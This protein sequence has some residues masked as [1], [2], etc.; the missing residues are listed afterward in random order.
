MSIQRFRVLLTILFLVLSLA[1]ALGSTVRPAGAVDHHEAPLLT[2]NAMLDATDFY[3]FV[4]PDGVVAGPTPLAGIPFDIVAYN[5]ADANIQFDEDIIPGFGSS[6]IPFQLLDANFRS[7][8]PL[9]VV[10]PDGSTAL[11]ELGVVPSPTT[12]STGE[13]QLLEISPDGGSFV[14]TLDIYFLVTFTN[15]ADGAV[16]VV[17][18][19]AE[20]VVIRV[21]AS[22][23]Y[24]YACPDDFLSVFGVTAD[25]CPG[26]QPG[27]TTVF[28]TTFVDINNPNNPAILWQTRPATAPSNRPPVLDPIAD[29]SVN[30]GESLTVPVRAT[31][32]DGHG[33]QLDVEGLPA[34]ASFIDN[35]DGTGSFDFSPDFDQSGSYGVTIIAT[36]DG[37]PNRSDRQTFTVTVNNVNRPP[38][39]GPFNDVTIN[40][41]ETATG[42]FSTTDPD[43]DGRTFE[44][45]GPDFCTVND[46]G[47]G[48]GT[49]SCGPGFDD[50]GTFPVTVTVSD[51]GEPVLSDSEEFTLTVLNVNR[52]PNLDPIGDQA[53]SEG[54][55]LSTPVRATDPD[56]DEILLDIAGLPPF[57]SFTDNGDGTGSI[58]FAPGFED[59]GTFEV[60]VIATDDGTPVL[61]DSET[62]TLIVNDDNQSPVLAPIS[63][64]EVNEGETA[65]ISITA[66]DLDGDGMTFEFEGPDFC[67]I[68][69]DGEGAG[70]LQCSPGFD[71]DETY[72]VTVTVTDNGNPALT[73]SATF[74]VTVIDVNRAPTLDP[75]E[76]QTITVGENVTIVVMADDPDDDDLTFTIVE[77]PP[78]CNLT[79]NGDGTGSIQCGPGAGDTG[80]HTMTVRASD[81]GIP[82]SVSRR[83]SP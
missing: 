29:Q 25:F 16:T 8:T 72:P 22:G 66:S 18:G 70:S 67:V 47:N 64:V 34:G 15:L 20:N 42:T 52:A 26:H 11:Y 56:E 32:P 74:T 17:D 71:D 44:V 41:G 61:S 21:E 31:D 69:D 6:T 39:L 19:G 80:E 12:A 50:S 53:M 5:D 14:A 63:D 27:A 68:S 48:A 57:A 35:R 28:P 7:A 4:N 23:S 43:G 37:N 40:E 10:F 13:M 9:T 49:W 33:I 82:I 2:L 51:D 79:D 73:D 54:E 30:E 46:E 81:D 1:G 3:A 24:S 65:T 76:D 59:A 38:L 45:D 83:P 62:L 55:T 78:F 58:D 77:G 36:D 75:I 60:T